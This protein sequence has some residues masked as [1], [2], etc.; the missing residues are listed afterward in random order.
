MQ[1]RLQALNK[2]L[3]I[4]SYSHSE[5]LEK[6]EEMEEAIRRVEEQ[7]HKEIALMQAMI[8]QAAQEDNIIKA[9]LK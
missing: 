1:D 6:Y 7:S 3:I 5:L 9:G 8:E 4:K 2:E